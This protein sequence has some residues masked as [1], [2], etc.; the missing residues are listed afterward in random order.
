MSLGGHSSRPVPDR[1]EPPWARVRAIPIHDDGEDLVPVTPGSGILTSPQYFNA[2][3]P[4][5]VPECFV[6]AS[7]LTALHAAA[8]ELPRGHRLLLL[9]AWRPL[10]LQRWLHR[11]VLAGQYAARPG[12]EPGEL[13]RHLSGYVAEPSGDPASPPFHLTGGAVDVTIAGPDGDELP[14]GTKHDE[15][16]P[17]SATAY[18]E[19]GQGPARDIAVARNRRLLYHVMTGAGFTNLPTEW[20]HYDLGNQL[21]AYLGGEPGARFG[22]A[23]PATGPETS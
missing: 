10:R 11:A 22:A 7:V 1:D 20:W 18:Y 3:L 5:A 17:A 23:A 16:T 2:G 12:A 15:M 19:Q 21:A 13:R 9:D 8:A 6:R 14:M 4:G